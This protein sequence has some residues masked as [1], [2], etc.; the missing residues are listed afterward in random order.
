MLGNSLINFIK[1]NNGGKYASVSKEERERLQSIV[2]DFVIKKSGYGSDFDIKSWASGIDILN[3]KSVDFLSNVKDGDNIMEGLANSMGKTTKAVMSSGKEIQLT[4]NKFKDF[5]ART[6]DSFSS[7][8]KIAKNGLKSFGAGLAGTLANVGINFLIGKVL[9]KAISAWQNYSNAQEN[10]IEESKTALSTLQENQNKIKSAQDVFNDIKSNT[11]IDSSGNEITRF[12]QLSRGVN[13][14]GENVSL[15]ASEFEE[16]NSILNSMSSAGLTATTSMAGLEAQVKEI[17]KSAN[18]D[19]LKGLGDWIEG[20]N[21]QNNQ[22]YTDSTKEVGLQ[23]KLSA[24]NKAYADVKDVNDKVQK[25][26]NLTLKERGENVDYAFFEDAVGKIDSSTKKGKELLA[27]N[28]KATDAKALKE[29]AKEYNL[30]ILDA[31]GEID[32]AKL[33][34]E[35]VQTQLG[36]IRTSLESEVESLVRESSGFLQALFENSPEF[37]KISDSAANAIGNI[38]GNIDYATISKHMMDS[39]GNLSRSMM[40]DWVNNLSNNVKNK[41][42]QDKLSQL[43]SLDTDSSKKTFKEYEKQAT[44]LIEDISSAVPELSETLLKDSSGIGDTLEE[45]GIAYKRVADTV[46]EEFANSL[47]LDNLD[48]ATDIISQQDVQNAE[49]LKQALLEAKQAAFDMNANPIFDSIEEADKTENAGDD[50]VKATQYLKEAKEMYDNGLYGTDDFKKRAKYLSPTGSEDPANFIEN[51]DKAARYLT[52]DGSGVSNFLNDLNKKGYATFENLSD[53]TKKW[54]Y[55]IQDLQKAAQD[56][57]MGFE[58]FMDMFGRLEDYGFSNN[59]ITSQEDGIEKITDK[60]TK[61]AQAK[62]ELAEMETTGQYT[63]VDENGNEQKTVANQTAIDAKKAEIAGLENDLN[64]LQNS[65]DQYNQAT[66]DSINQQIEKSKQMYSSLKEER[67]KILAEN[68]YGEN[69][70]EVVRGL[71]EQLKRIAQDGFFEIDGEMNIVNEDEVKSELES[72]YVELPVDINASFDDLKDKAEASLRDVQEI[73]NAN[74]VPVRLDLESDNAANI[75]SQIAAIVTSMSKLKNED[76]TIDIHAEG[77]EEAISVLMALVARKQEVAQPV[78]MSVDTGKLDGDLAT[79]IGKLQEFQ[80]AYNELERLNTLKAAGVNVD[81]SEAQTKLNNITSE[82]Q[83]LDGKQAEIMATLNVDTS[84]MATIQSSISAITPEIMV[85]AGVDSA[86]VEAY[87]NAEHNSKGTVTWDNNSS[88]VDSYA[89]T[90]KSARGMVTWW[91]N[92]NNVKTTFSATGTVNWTNANGPGHASGTM[93]S[94]ARANGT[95]YNTLNMSP[96]H[97]SGNV[98]LPKDEKALVNELP[99]PESIVR[100][101]VWSLIPGGAHIEQLKKGDIIFNGEQTEQLLKHGSISGHGRAYA[102]GSVGNV[103][104]LVR[105]PL[106][107]YA[108]GFGG[109]VLGAGGSGSQA[110]FG[111]GNS[112]K[113]NSNNGNKATNTAKKVAKETKKAADNAKEFEETLDHIVTLIDRLERTISNLERTVG[114]TYETLET[115]TDALRKQ[116]IETTKEISIQEQAYQRYL[117]EAN[118]VGLSEEYAEKVRNGLIDLE[119][120]TDETLN[121]SIKKYQEYYEKA[122]D[123]RD[124]VEELKESVQS[125]YEQAFNNIADEFD[126]ILSQIDHRRNILEGYIDQTESQGYIVSTEYY[127]ELIKNEQNNLNELTKKRNELIASLNDAVANGNIKMYS[128]SW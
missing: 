42:V 72:E 116:M 28:Q 114:N 122:L 14:L 123:A 88:A 29:L 62:K 36:D 38:F 80:T 113:G 111:G 79:V 121:D 33:T 7:F 98:S 31:K 48:L 93:L 68:R 126:N 120:I 55:N 8:G 50:Y 90:E 25:I 97:A 100:D 64:E 11:V 61:L 78:V 23:Q 95:A 99:K 119:T 46:G 65:L 108:S 87:Q 77:A 34:S 112:N 107:A 74:A 66:A 18:I 83:S 57:G 51:Y 56:M 115:R 101:G 91:N 5:F 70:D 75:D 53:G 26:E 52:E 59:F 128:E 82:I 45:A 39:N 58:F 40:E 44:G 19:S 103:R 13:S 89:A 67:D 35:E 32:Q 117:E 6:K 47:S 1:G 96:A 71:D 73:V 60:T 105:T 106:S 41:G 9:D 92:T 27:L 22:M 84:S 104:D 54:S 49:Q 43:F 24:L 102:D 86:L 3:D 127:S 12:E 85:K 20:F 109:G 63:T 17:R 124:A 10:A 21:A 16:Y 15:T 30:D 37:D 69:T 2:D 118:S 110:N 76:G 81:T 94:P 4:G 125:L